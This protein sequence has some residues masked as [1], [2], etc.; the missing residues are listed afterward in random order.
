MTTKYG[1]FEVMNDKGDKFKVNG[2][3]LKHYFEGDSMGKVEE[4]TFHDSTTT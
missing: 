3:R 2:H 4:V 1:Y